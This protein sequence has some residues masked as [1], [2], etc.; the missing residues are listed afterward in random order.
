MYQHQEIS[1]LL[2]HTLWKLNRCDSDFLSY[3]DY[4]EVQLFYLSL[5]TCESATTIQAILSK[6]CVVLQL[7]LT[8]LTFICHLRLKAIIQDFLSAIAIHF[9]PF[10][11]ICHLQAIIPNFLF[12]TAIHSSPFNF[13][14]FLFSI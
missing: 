11:S 12:I 13:I 9:P 14:Y 10:N 1:H 5:F 8:L 6:L 3:S 7:H 4:Y 2:N